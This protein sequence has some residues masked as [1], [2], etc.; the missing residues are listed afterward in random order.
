MPVTGPER[1]P[2]CNYDLRGLPPPHRCPECGLAYDEHTRIWRPGHG[3]LGWGTLLLAPLI[4]VGFLLM[5]VD[6]CGLFAVFFFVAAFYVP[7]VLWRERSI[8]GGR[9]VA[10]LPEGV[11]VRTAELSDTVPW[12]HIERA[13]CGP[14]RT[15]YLETTGTRGD[16]PLTGIFEADEVESFCASIAAGR[17]RAVR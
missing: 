12:I 4:V 6:G 14:G 10:V 5:L 8:R 9:W 11:R 1:C 15:V 3:S 13:T 16:I 17:Q 2:Q 7:L